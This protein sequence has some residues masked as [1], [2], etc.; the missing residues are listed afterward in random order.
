VPEHAIPSPPPAALESAEAPEPISIPT[1][2]ISHITEEDYEHVY[3][4]AEDSFILL[5]ALEADA[6]VLRDLKPALC[7]EIGSGSGIAST[8][9]GTLLGSGEACVMST[10]INA[11][12]AAVTLRTGD[13]NDVAL[14]PILGNLLDPVEARMAGQIDLLIFNPP[15]V[16]TD[17]D[18]LVATQNGRDIGGAWAGGSLGMAVT[19]I[20][21]EKLPVSQIKV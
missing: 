17:D 21:L 12:A 1:P 4:P 15:Y 8:F 20:L 7:V 13:A 19:N 10:D 18:E 9:M 2:Q 14:N 3:E 6:L 11:Y 16:V 5:D